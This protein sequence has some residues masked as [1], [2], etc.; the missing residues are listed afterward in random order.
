M[1]DMLVKLYALEDEDLFVSRY[2]DNGII[3]KQAYRG[4]KHII[5]DFIKKNFDANLWP[6]ECERAMN[7]DPV[8]CFIAVKEKK[9][10]GF[11]CYDGTTRGFFGPIGVK[12]EYRKHGIGGFLLKRTLFAMREY[13]YAYAVIGWADPDAFS[14]YKRYAGAEVI[15]GSSNEKSAYR[16]MIT[17]E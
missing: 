7:N 3:I 5:M 10:I 11:S 4:D 9:L 13:G 15:E 16:N 14:F 12:E 2:Q 8:S 17:C 1:A 6:N